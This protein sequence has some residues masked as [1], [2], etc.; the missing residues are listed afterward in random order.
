[1][2]DKRMAHQHHATFESIRCIDEAGSEFSAIRGQHELGFLAHPMSRSIGILL[3][4]NQSRGQ[5]GSSRKGDG[6]GQCG[7]CGT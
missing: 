3:P 2:T 5:R 1:M 4:I 7:L 6:A